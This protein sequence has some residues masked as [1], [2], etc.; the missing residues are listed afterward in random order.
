MDREDSFVNWKRQ[1]KVS[2]NK[3]YKKKYYHL[4]I[5][6]I[7]RFKCNQMVE[8]KKK[9]VCSDVLKNILFKYVRVVTGL[10]R[11]KVILIYD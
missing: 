9:V 6:C 1:V 5:K 7:K 3:I 2:R 8:S 4:N 10:K 11:R